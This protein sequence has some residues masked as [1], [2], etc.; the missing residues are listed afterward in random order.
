MYDNE[1]QEK[2]MNTSCKAEGEKHSRINDVKE[3]KKEKKEESSFP[4]A[5]GMQRHT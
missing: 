5:N 3:K 2:N 4:L 1:A